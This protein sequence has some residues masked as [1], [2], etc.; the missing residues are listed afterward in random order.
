MLS[1]KVLKNTDFSDILLVKS[2]LI[3]ERY[4]KQKLKRYEWYHTKKKIRRF[5][6]F[7]IT[8]RFSPL[9]SARQI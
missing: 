6:I 8:M 9:F 3:K 7:I 1:V 2:T 4:Q 5:F